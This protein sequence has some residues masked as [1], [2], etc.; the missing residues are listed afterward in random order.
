MKVRTAATLCLLAVSV[1]ALSE[2]K[3]WDREP[4]SVLGIELGAEVPKNVPECPSYS[5]G[6]YKPPSQLCISGHDSPYSDKLRMLEGLPFKDMAIRGTLTIQDGK[7]LNVTLDMR[8]EEDYPDMAAI[9]IEKYGEPTSK[10]NSEVT[11]KSGGKFSSESWTWIGKKNSI[12]LFER[13]GRIDRS[14]VV[15]SNNALVE[16]YKRAEQEKTKKSASEF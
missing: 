15:F 11:S 1:S 3:R 7:V 4:S 6:G 14:A 5:A 12:F 9:L 2:T 8:R 10:E 16:T 13:S